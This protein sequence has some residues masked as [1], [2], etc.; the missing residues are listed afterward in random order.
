MAIEMTE[1][2]SSV[3]R[4]EGAV[5]RVTFHNEESGYS[6]LKV[7]VKGRRDHVAVVGFTSSV[8]PGETIEGLGNW[9]QNKEYGLQFKA[10]T[11]RTIPPSTLEGIE[12]YLA[13]GMIKGIG[14]HFSKKL[15]EAFGFEVFDIIE[16]YPQKLCSVDKIGMKRVESIVSAW[17][18]Q[19]V[20]RSI[21]V[22]LQSHGVSTSKAVRIYKT[23]GQNAVE[24]VRENPYQLAR[25]IHGIGFKSA[26][27]IAGK[28]GIEKNSMIRARAGI[29]F[30]LAEQIQDGHCAYPEKDL[31]EKSS[32][33]LGIETA[34]LVEALQFELTEKQLLKEVIHDKICIYPAA[35][36]FFEREVANSISD[37]LLCSPEPSWGVIDLEKAIPWVEAKV[38]LHLAEL[39]REAVKIALQ[40]KMTIITGG[41]GTGKSTLTKAIVT[42][43]KAKGVRIALCSP[44]GRAAKRLSE[45]TGLEAKTI[46]RTLGFNHSKSG[47]MY[48]R[49]FPLPIDLLLIDE[50]SMVDI[51]LM[52]SLLK[53]VPS[54]A[55]VIIIGDIDQLPSVGPGKVLEDLILSGS[56]PVIKLTEVFRQAAQSQIIQ[57]AH[58]IN[59][60]YFPDLDCTDQ[61]DFYFISSDDPDA[62]VSKIIELVQNRIPQKFGF[63]PVRDIQVL[64]PMLRG[65]LGARNLNQE[66]QKVL[67]PN[68][69]VRVDRFGYSFCVGDKVMVLQ[70]DYN[71]DVF[72]GDMGFIKNIFPE[73][74]ECYV[75]FEDREVLFNLN[76]LDILQPAYTITIHKSQGS[77]YPV[78]VIPVATQHYM[79]LKRNLIYTGVT[80]G[81]KLVILI[82]QK[83]ALFI[84]VKSMNNELRWTNLKIKIQKKFC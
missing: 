5:E 64:C 81:K 79:M 23:Y 41:P 73:E 55:A 15:V 31:L 67:N 80:R 50:V 3:D 29:Q 2:N 32:Q 12:K 28:L 10:H 40:S 24:K 19:K 30:V 49:N 78:V 33:L 56:I 68:P 25:D 62:T 70:N 20:I 6:V 82:G 63:H 46:H 17:K 54:H 48:D 39:Q 83:K 11:I 58:R 45:C 76:E 34:I 42:I 36:H 4:V 27:L 75:H 7:A 52:Y 35:I 44:T 47:F 21:M 74:Q 57:A 38:S 14:P 59:E 72:N 84:A 69:T 60:G 51:H 65:S 22:F 61:S 37:L 53:A 18:D 9:I 77:E 66:L 26:D 43:L 16:N 71:K 8:M 13:S 1:A